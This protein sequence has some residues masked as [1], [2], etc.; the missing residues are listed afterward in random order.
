LR[1][2]ARADRR[3]GSVGLLLRLDR[4]AVADHPAVQRTAAAPHVKGVFHPAARHHP[5]VRPFV[6]EKLAAGWSFDEIV[7][8]APRLLRFT[9]Y[10]L[11]DHMEEIDLRVAEGIAAEERGEFQ[12]GEEAMAEI[13]AEFE[14]RRSGE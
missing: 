13:R 6:E 12:D 11:G 4:R 9:K 5:R 8:D 7:C 10:F 1:A 2:R 14:A 3:P